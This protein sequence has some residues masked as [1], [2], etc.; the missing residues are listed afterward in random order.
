M[1]SYYYSKAALEVYA[2][3]QAVK[4]IDFENAEYTGWLV[5]RQNEYVLLPLNNIWSTYTIKRSHIKKIYHL[6]NNQLIPKEVE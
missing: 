5:P 3:Y 6:T 4:I 2:L 1:T